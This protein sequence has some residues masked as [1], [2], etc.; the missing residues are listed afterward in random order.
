MNELND[1]FI[2]TYWWLSFFGGLHCLT[3]VIYIRYFNR[4]DGNQTLLTAYLSIISIYFFMG[5]LTQ[6]NSPIP[7]HI[8]FNEIN[9]LYFLLMPLLYLYCKRCLLPKNKNYFIS[10]HYIPFALMFTFATLDLTLQLTAYPADGSTL[11]EILKGVNHSYLGTILPALIS[12]Q[13]C[14]YFIALWVLFHR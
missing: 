6:D 3:F 7:L 10:K 5:M 9:T 2:Q 4:A 1:F 12:I 8:V 11:V 13:T 14:C